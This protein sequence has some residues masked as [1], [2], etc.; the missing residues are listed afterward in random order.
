MHA[1]GGALFR[2]VQNC[3]LK[4]RPFKPLPSHKTPRVTIR[5]FCAVP[6]S[7]LLAFSS[8]FRLAH[9]LLSVSC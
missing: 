9:T 6:L 1:R 4:N 8:L 7:L 2:C 3:F 5:P